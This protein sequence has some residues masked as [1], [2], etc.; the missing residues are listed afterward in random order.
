MITKIDKSELYSGLYK[1]ASMIFGFTIFLIILTGSGFAL[2]YNLRQK[3][4]YKD[5]YNTEKELVL[6]NEKFKA[7]IR[8]Y[9]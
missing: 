5:L 1:T 7:T 3:V 8:L 6:L 2:I 9:Q 4:I